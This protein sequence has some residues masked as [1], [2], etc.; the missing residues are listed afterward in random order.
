M[1]KNIELMCAEEFGGKTVKCVRKKAAL[2][3]NAQNKITVL[4][5]IALSF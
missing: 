1:L 4:H 5:C 3:A 2:P